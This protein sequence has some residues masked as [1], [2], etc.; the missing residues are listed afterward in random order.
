MT[1]KGTLL[2]AAF[3][4]VSAV[5]VARAHSQ[6]AIENGL[7]PRMALPRQNLIPEPKEPQGQAPTYIPDPYANLHKPNAEA[8][9][10]E[11]ADTAAWRDRCVANVETDPRTGVDRYQFKTA[12]G[13]YCQ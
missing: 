8:I 1:L 13:P 2:F 12:A 10:K 5:M 4:I 11:K 7:A 3:V 9:A 6:V